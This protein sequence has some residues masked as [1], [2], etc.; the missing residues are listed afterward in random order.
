MKKM[1]IIF[2][3]LVVLLSITVFGMIKIFSDEQAKAKEKIGHRYVLGKDTILVI[4]FSTIKD[5]YTIYGGQEVAPELLST[6]V[7]VK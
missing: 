2:G 7:E 4:D 3:C 6:L 5:T 1:L